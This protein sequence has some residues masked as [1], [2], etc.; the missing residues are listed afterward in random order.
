MPDEFEAIRDIATESAHSL[1]SIGKK[2][3]N[4]YRHR[5]FDTSH[6]IVV[7]LS[8]PNRYTYSAELIRQGYRL[9]EFS[10]FL[11]DYYEA[12]DEKQTATAYTLA[13]KATFRG[14][15]D[16]ARQRGATQ[17]V[18]DMDIFTAAKRSGSLPY[19]QFLTRAPQLLPH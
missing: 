13:L 2:V 18:I 15:T 9:A 11:S 5:D 12:V 16:L 8:L 19:A 14:A 3:C 10:N 6:L 7:I 4:H 17:K 1:L